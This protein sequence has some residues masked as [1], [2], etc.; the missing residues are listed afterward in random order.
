MLRS[1]VVFAMV[2]AVCFLPRLMEGAFEPLPLG[3]IHE[4]YVSKENIP[5]LYSAVLE[6]PP[7]P[8]NEK[9][10]EAQPPGTVWVP[11]YWSWSAEEKEY[12]WISGF[13]RKP[14]PERVWIEGLWREFDELGWVWL[15]GFW[16]AHLLEESSFIQAAPPGVI[17]EVP[18]FPESGNFFWD[19]GYW[20]YNSKLSGYEWIGGT[21][22]PFDPNWVLIPAHYEWRPEG[23]IFVS[24]YWDWPLNLRGVSYIPVLIPKTSR[25]SYFD[26]AVERKDAQIYQLLLCYYPDYLNL[27]LHVF[28][29]HPERWATIA[30]T[31]WQWHSWWS[32]PWSDQWGLWWWY[33]HPGSFEPLGLTSEMI[34]KI[35]SANPRL[36]QMT[37]DILPPV[38]VTPKGV[39]SPESIWSVLKKKQSAGSF[40]PI[41]PSDPKAVEKIQEDALKEIQSKVRLP[42]LEKEVEPSKRGKLYG[43]R[44]TIATPEALTEGKQEK[45]IVTPPPKPVFDHGVLQK[46]V[47]ANPPSE[48]E[49]LSKSSLK[50]KIITPDI[51]LL[52][53]KVLKEMRASVG[54]QPHAKFQHIPPPNPSII[55]QLLP[56]PRV[57]PPIELDE[58]DSSKMKN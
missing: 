25:S 1:T 53:V 38:I 55:H 7:D 31:W 49:G 4:A 13:Y 35:H 42:R 8:I 10:P 9:K 52:P 6:E 47:T 11:G 18:G 16:S 23:Y 36:L 21:W 29:Y 14:P 58:K 48:Y 19:A 37:T 28:H 33:T 57:G 26:T 34:E 15:N 12:V 24:A 2:L 56:G 54:D 44:E 5:V 46:I 40:L 45:K 43:T 50:S 41:L 17:S 30:P 51:Q 22:V 20:N 32:L 3:V 27:C 39:I